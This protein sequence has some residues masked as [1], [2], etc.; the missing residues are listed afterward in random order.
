MSYDVLRV[1]DIPIV[2]AQTATHGVDNMS[3]PRDRNHK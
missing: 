2:M 1:I 3:S